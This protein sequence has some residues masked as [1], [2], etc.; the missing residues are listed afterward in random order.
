MP[1]LSDS[2]FVFLEDNVSERLAN[3]GSPALPCFFAVA[4]WT[5]EYAGKLKI[6]FG[7]CI[8]NS[9]FRILWSI[10]DVCPVGVTRRRQ[11]R[12]EFLLF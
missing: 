4:E 6:I 9:R 2:Y 1:G 5:F 3:R 8:L 10:L 11:G 7:W 12:T